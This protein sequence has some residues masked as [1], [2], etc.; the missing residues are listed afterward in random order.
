M[1]PKVALV[2]NYI[3]NVTDHFQEGL[4]LGLPF[5]ACI[6]HSISSLRNAALKR[7]TTTILIALRGRSDPSLSRN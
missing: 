2:V 4:F 3:F 6:L 1:F 7:D 5:S